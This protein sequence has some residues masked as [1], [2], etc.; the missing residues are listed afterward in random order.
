M[1]QAMSDEVADVP[2]QVLDNAGTVAT[3]CFVRDV[4]A[5]PAIRKVRD[6]RIDTASPP[7]STLVDVSRLFLPDLLLEVEAVAVAPDTA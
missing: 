1:N 3:P 7:A 2:S 5:V 6:E 4:S